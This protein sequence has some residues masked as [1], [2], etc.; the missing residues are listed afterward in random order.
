LLYRDDAKLV[1]GIVQDVLSKLNQVD[2]GK[3]KG[4]VGIEK[5]ISSIESLLH[6]ES[7]DVRV[8]GIWGM[9]GIGKTTIAEEAFLKLRSKYESCCFMANVREESERYGVSSLK[10]RKKTFINSIRGRRFER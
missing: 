1:D 4:L 3:S 5:Q 10:L 9:P 8:L 2:Q 6:L 7:E